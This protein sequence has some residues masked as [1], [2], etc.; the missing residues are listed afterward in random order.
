[1]SSANELRS[2]PW[3]N[4]NRYEVSGFKD[5][6]LEDLMIPLPNATNEFNPYIIS[7]SISISQVKRSLTNPPMYLTSNGTKRRLLWRPE[8]LSCNPGLTIDLYF[9]LSQMNLGVL[10][11]VHL[12][13][14]FGEMSQFISM[15][16]IRQYPSLPWNLRLMSKNSELTWTDITTL[17]TILM[18]DEWDWDYLTTSIDANIIMNNPEYPWNYDLLYSSNVRLPS[19]PPDM[20]RIIKSNLISRK[21]RM[22]WKQISI[23]LN[24]SILP[25]YPEL[26]EIV[27]SYQD[28]IRLNPSCTA[29]T[30]RGEISLDDWKRIAQVMNPSEISKLMKMRRCPTGEEIDDVILKR[31]LI[32]DRILKR[33]RDISFTEK[34]RCELSKVLTR[35]QM[36]KFNIR[37]T[38][39]SLSENR[40]ITIEWILSLRNL[41]KFSIDSMHKFMSL[42]GIM[43]SNHFRWIPEKLAMN[44]NLTV[45]F[46]RHLN[47]FYNYGIDYSMITPHISENEIINHPGK[48]WRPSKILERRELSLN[49]LSR[50]I[51]DP[52]AFIRDNPRVVRSL[53]MSSLVQVLERYPHLKSYCRHIQGN[54]AIPVRLLELM[55]AR[56]EDYAHRLSLGDVLSRRI[57]HRRVMNNTH[58]PMIY[59]TL[60]DMGCHDIVI[61]SITPMR[62]VDSFYDLE[63]VF[64]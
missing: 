61:R 3:L 7:N 9:T 54:G 57:A 25:Q 32:N 38:L 37:A 22:D 33:C 52:M 56:I 50:F 26:E 31:G 48:H 30:I 1:M 28:M 36:N 39:S 60:I 11:A 43:N 46:V 19:M 64:I 15:R 6:T 41:A 62:I 42:E 10:N 17:N 49:L 14:S 47:T 59:R 58:I 5:L 63:I 34:Y 29:E 18:E 51:K 8:A 55:N 27:T 23:R 20:R 2:Y 4:W 21:E 35:E 16:E 44:E 13:L 40:N 45:D 53:G 12:G 24:L